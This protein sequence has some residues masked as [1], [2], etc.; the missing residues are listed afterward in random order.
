MFRRFYSQVVFPWILDFEM[1]RPHIMAHRKDALKNVQGT[2]LEIGIGTGLNLSCYPPS[3]KKIS[4]VDI[5][6]GMNRYLQKRIEKCSIEMEFHLLK[7]DETLPFEDDSFDSVVST[8]TLCSI[9]N[10]SQ[11]LS[12]I[13][14]V[15]KPA[16]KYFFLEHGLSKDP[17]IQKWQ[18]RMNPFQ[19]TFAEGCRLNRPIRGLIQKSGF[20]F[21]EIKEYYLEKMLKHM[22]YLYQGIAVKK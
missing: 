11:A 17:R 21:R 14:R 19:R 5:N 6:P 8:W 20:E 15:L 16:G 4:T 2:V 7:V 10:V 13:R 9:P 1:S 12:E 18:Q 22:G 3:V